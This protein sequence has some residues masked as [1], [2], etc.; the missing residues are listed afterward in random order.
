M[1]PSLSSLINSLKKTHPKTPIEMQ[2]Q[3]HEKMQ[4]TGFFRSRTSSRI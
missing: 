1:L 2:N 4:K 3:L